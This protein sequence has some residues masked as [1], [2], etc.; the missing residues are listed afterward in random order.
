MFFDMIKIV[1]YFVVVNWVCWEER[2]ID[3]VC[4]Y[5]IIFIEFLVYN[6]IIINREMG[7]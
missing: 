1:C 6:I 7:C 4:D 3:S 2:E 5:K